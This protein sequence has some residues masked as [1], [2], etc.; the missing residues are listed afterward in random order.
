MASPPIISKAYEA[1]I[2]FITAG[3]TPSSIINFQP[4]AQVKERVLDLIDREKNQSLSPEEKQELD[5]Y[6][7]LEHLIRLAKARAYQYLPQP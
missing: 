6:M 5:N 7:I 3:S 2:D 1:L 4:S